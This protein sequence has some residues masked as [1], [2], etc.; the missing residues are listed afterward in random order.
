MRDFTYLNLLHSSF[1]LEFKSTKSNIERLVLNQNSASASA[2]KYLDLIRT[3]FLVLALLQLADW[4]STVRGVY[5]GRQE[6]NFIISFLAAHV[7]ILAA[8]TIIKVAAIF[9]TWVYLRMAAERSTKVVLVPLAIV[10]A[11]Y[12]VIVINNY[13]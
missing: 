10:T 2:D 3:L 7:G 6:Q 11:I 13:F 8:V 4:D 12:A 5:M 9:L 1:K